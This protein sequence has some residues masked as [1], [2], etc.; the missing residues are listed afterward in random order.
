MIYIVAR[1]FTSHGAYG[2][3]GESGR[4]ISMG[5]TSCASDGSSSGV[6]Y[7]VGGELGSATA[8]EMG[9]GS[10]S[11]NVLLFC[12]TVSCENLA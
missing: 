8:A 12:F 7:D 5:T 3:T 9:S 10:C 6:A 2:I 11:K 1:C 4:S